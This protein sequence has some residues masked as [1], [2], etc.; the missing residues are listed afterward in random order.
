MEAPPKHVPKLIVF[1]LDM[2]MWSPEM[3]ELSSKPTKSIHGSFLHNFGE[4]VVGAQD[5]KSND[6]VTIFPGALLAMQELYQLKEFSN[7]KVAAASSSLE[8][9]YSHAC[10]DILEILPGVP[11]R[12]IFSF[13]AIGRTKECGDLTS[14]KK[15]HFKKIKNESNIEFNDMLFFDDCNWSD[16]VGKIEQAHGVMGQRTPEGLTV[17]EWRSA[18]V[19]FDQERGSVEEI[20]DGGSSEGDTGRSSSSSG[21]GGGG[22]GG[23]K[24]E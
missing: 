1:D 8:P 18:L 20:G 24:K 23:E 17:S 16:H 19:R 15:T 3:H 11:M 10:L 14:D 21:G 13:F 9:T 6:I 5:L 4:G 2:C 12:N 7:T 22:G